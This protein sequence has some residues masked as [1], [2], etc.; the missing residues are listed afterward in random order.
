MRK[1][2]EVLEH[3]TEAGLDFLD[4]ILGRH[5]DSVIL[6]PDCL[7]AHVTNL[8]AVNARQK[9]RTAEQRGLAGT[10]RS[11]DG[12]HLAFLH[13]DRDILQNLKSVELFFDMIHFKKIRTHAISS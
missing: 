12:K 10:G 2:I 8:P 3:Q 11:Y 1:K 4:F 6:C 9:R 7:F 13:M 5:A